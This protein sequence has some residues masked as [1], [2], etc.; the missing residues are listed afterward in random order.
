MVAFSPKKEVNFVK[1]P[2]KYEHIEATCVPRRALFCLRHS[3]QIFVLVSL[4]FGK[5]GKIKKI[6]KNS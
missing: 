5:N 4:K 1:E 6:K 2:E 3:K